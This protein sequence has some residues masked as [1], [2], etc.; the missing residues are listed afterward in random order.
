MS[1]NQV[2]IIVKSPSFQH[3]FSIRRAN[4]EEIQDERSVG[5]IDEVREVLQ[6]SAKLAAERLVDGIGSNNENIA[7]KSATEL[8]DRSG[9]PKE[10]KVSGDKDVGTTI[11]IEAKQMAVLTESLNLDNIKPVEAAAPTSG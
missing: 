6:K 4:V 1:R 2:G 7:I 11:I 10:Q 9:Y 8:L 3:Q 5:A